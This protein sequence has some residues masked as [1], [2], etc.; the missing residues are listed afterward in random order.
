MLREGLIQVY[1][2]QSERTNFA[3]FGLSLRASGQGLCTF[4]ASFAP[5][6]LMEGID[7]AASCLKP[8]LVVDESARNDL[9]ASDDPNEKARK[10]SETYLRARTAMLSGKFDV[11]IFR[12]IHRA[13]KQGLIPLERLLALM[14]EKPKHVEL[15]LT[16]P[17]AD[18]RVVDKAD[19]VTEMV[20]HKSVSF[21]LQG[22]ERSDRKTI[23]VITGNGK[24]KTTYCLGKAMLRSS[25]GT[26]ALIFQFIK[27]PQLYGEIM[28]IERFPNIEIKSM[29]MG[30]LSKHSP[31]DKKHADAAQ[32]AWKAWLKMI[33]SE[34][35]D[36]IVLDEINVATYHGLISGPRV[37]EA[38]F[39]EPQKFDIFLS[40]RHAHPDVIDVATT[41]I[42]MKEI[43][44]PFKKGIMARKGIEF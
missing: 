10:T 32:Q 14:G 42:E 13:V 44:H 43:K 1:T 39:L 25:L 20:L 40:G 35:Y 5:Y 27:S 41:V 21:Q 34:R 8:N 2:G 18:E 30:F 7:G 38:L 6:E 19:Y 31:L 16:G 36:L 26:S 37:R 22:N 28:A 17:E 3:P 9:S 29:G 24:G 12:G 4:L 33:H 15:V 11:V 23:Q